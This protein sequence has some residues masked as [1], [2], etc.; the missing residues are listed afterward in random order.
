MKKLTSVSF[1]DAISLSLELAS[2]KPQIEWVSLFNAL[3]R[4]LAKEITCKKNL[5]SYNNA[6]M[7]G[8][9]YMA[10]DG[11]KK[12]TIKKTILAGDI[13]NACL[14]KD[15][16]YKIMTGA[17]IPDDVDTIVP[18][19]DTSFYDDCFVEIPSI[20]KK[21]NA[22]RLKG[23]E[24]Q[25]GSLLFD[26]GDVLSAPVIAMLASQGITH[27]EVYRKLKIA[28]FSTGDEL[29]EPWENASEDEIYDVNS[30]ALISLFSEHGFEAHYCGVI[31]DNL[32]EATRYFS[33]M[34]KYDA[35]VTS[36]GIS[37]GEADFV[38]KAL[39]SNG[40]EALFHGI[41]I[42]PGKPTMMGK[43]GETIVASMPGNPLAAFVNA[44]IF[45]IPLF[46]KLQG[47]K[48]F[49]FHYIK[50]INQTFLK[51]KLGR[52]NIVLGNLENEKFEAFEHN[53]YGS[54][55]ITPL[56]GSNS[57]L[58][59]NEKIEHCHIGDEV[60]ILSFKSSFSSKKELFKN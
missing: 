28:V 56:I 11:G 47:Q 40:L 6:A 42:K 37:M 25:V 60:K 38:E 16:C 59:C 32:E 4:T 10:V 9:A 58:I 31:P 7:D 48:K 22:V 2:S 54:G 51:T 23:E 27:I 53:K 44:F 24:Q 39:L 21:G 19:E 17:K 29:K 20:F 46:K 55:M 14:E 35:L 33:D 3:G 26:E 13:V 45:L 34:K 5:P 18:F 41:N 43:M 36:G 8:F 30:I 52:V 50:A 15:E 57:I 1:D 49:N 12:L